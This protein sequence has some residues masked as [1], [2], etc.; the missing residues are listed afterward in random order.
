ME[1]GGGE[2]DFGGGEDMIMYQVFLL[3][4]FYFSYVLN[5]IHPVL[6][7]FTCQEIKIPITV[8]SSTSPLPYISLFFPPLPDITPP[9]HK[10]P[11]TR[12]ST[13]QHRP[14]Q[15]PPPPR[16]PKNPPLA[17]KMPKS[18]PVRPETEFVNSGVVDVVCAV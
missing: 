18:N 5:R 6:F 12:H 14:S 2:T 10:H 11:Q 3:N 7:L 9:L 17:Q 15:T 4:T 13:H 16:G 1:D 8:I